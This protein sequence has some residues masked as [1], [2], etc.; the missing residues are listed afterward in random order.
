MT[1]AVSCL[2]ITR[3]RPALAARAIGCFARQRYAARELVIVNQ[4]GAE[5]RARL[6]D[7]ARAHEISDVRIIDADPG[8]RLG[9]LRNISL[10]AAEGDLVCIWDDDDC[11]HPDRLAVQVRELLGNDAHTCFLSDHLQLFEQDGSLYWIDWTLPEP[12]ARFPLLPGTMLM[13]NDRRFRYPE[14]GRY[15]HFGEDWGVLIELHEQVRVHHI[16]GHGHLYLYSYHGE[17][18]FPLAHH[19]KIGIRARPHAAMSVLEPEIRAAMAH[20]PVPRPVL[21]HGAE[22]P[23]YS[24]SEGPGEDTWH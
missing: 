16:S 11:S 8:L 6:A 14:S 19:R 18:T 12:K 20:Y 23:M 21:V 7:L 9:A 5:Y 1:P 15:E 22:G 17:N 10:D 4:G 3:D 13:T 24:I 2:M